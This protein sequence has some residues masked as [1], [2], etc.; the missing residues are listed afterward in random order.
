MNGGGISQSIQMSSSSPKNTSLY[1]ILS[2]YRLESVLVTYFVKT[3][4]ADAHHKLGKWE[5]TIF[6]SA[7]FTRIRIF[8][9]PRLFLSGYGCRPYV[10]GEFESESGKKINPLSRV[11]KNKS[12]TNEIAF[13]HLVICNLIDSE[14]GYFRFRP[15]CF[16][17]WRS[18]LKQFV[19]STIKSFAQSKIC[20]HQQL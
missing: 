5:R 10:S 1:S 13:N 7:S 4:S 9:N 18:C 19:S 11:E 15:T 8:S 14:I 12:A 20:D 2:R 6:S 3:F 17:S 16:S